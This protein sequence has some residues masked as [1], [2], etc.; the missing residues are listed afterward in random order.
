MP[1]VCQHKERQQPGKKR[2]KA[3]FLDGVSFQRDLA[4]SKKYDHTYRKVVLK[5][6]LVVGVV[7]AGD[8]PQDKFH[9]IN[10]TS[11]DFSFYL[12]FSMRSIGQH[13]LSS[14]LVTD[15]L[16]RIRGCIF[17]PGSD[18]MNK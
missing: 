17:Q 2:A 8:R 7:F 6:W 3:E 1:K 4:L 5:D 14:P 18:I 9:H 11:R 10:C 12:V 13:C 16:V 15:S